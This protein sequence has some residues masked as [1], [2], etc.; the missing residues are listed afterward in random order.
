[1]VVPLRPF[2]LAVADRLTSRAS[3]STRAFLKPARAM[4]LR[5]QD[6]LACSINIADLAGLEDSSPASVFLRYRAKV[7]FAC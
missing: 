3:F 1:M 6:S 5:R 4:L 7:S 2:F